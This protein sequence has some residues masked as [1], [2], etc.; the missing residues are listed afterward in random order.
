MKRSKLRPDKNRTVDAVPPGM[1]MPTLRSRPSPFVRARRLPHQRHL[2]HR[3]RGRT[4]RLLAPR[5]RTSLTAKQER[6]L[7]PSTRTRRH[8]A[9]AALDQ[10]AAHRESRREAVAAAPATATGPQ[11]T[12]AYF[13]AP[14]ASTAPARIAPP[15]VAA[16]PTPDTAH[17]QRRTTTKRCCGLAPT[18]CFLGP[19]S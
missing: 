5:H 6:P 13:T 4:R 10:R 11:H 18:L 7:L 19:R 15:P 8:H 16:P 1:V 2:E 17:E 9:R 3:N 12:H 14:D